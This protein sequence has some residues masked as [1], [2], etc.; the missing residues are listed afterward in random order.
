MCLLELEKT[1]ICILWRVGLGGG[2]GGGGGGKKDHL[3]K[4]KY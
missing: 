1:A 2:G 4:C 3:E